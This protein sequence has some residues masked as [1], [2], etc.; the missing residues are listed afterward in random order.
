MTGVYRVQEGKE[1]AMCG[2]THWG[3]LYCPFKQCEGCGEL[4]D[5]ACSD[6]QIDLGATVLVCEK[7]S[8]RDRHELHIHGPRNKRKLE[9][10][11]RE[12]AG[13]GDTRAEQIKV[14]GD[15]PVLAY[16]HPYWQCPNNEKHALK[17][18]SRE[19][20]CVTLWCETCRVEAIWKGA[21]RPE[22]STRELREALAKRTIR[23]SRDRGEPDPTPAFPFEVV[24]SMKEWE[25][26]EAALAAQP[27]PK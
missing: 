12:A 13:Q 2:G 22:A 10:D 25:Q 21:P 9:Q 18:T 1:C 4:T 19:L 23:Y 16:G 3:S 6:C 26:I 11:G 14:S 8:C 24:F 17:F 7:S 5:M 15:V 20:R 27:E